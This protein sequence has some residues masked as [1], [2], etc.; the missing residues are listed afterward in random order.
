MQVAGEVYGG[1]AASA[2]AQQHGEQFAV[3][4]PAGAVGDAVFHGV[5]Q[6]G[7]NRVIFMVQGACGVKL[8]QGC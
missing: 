8:E 4:Q 7:A 6:R 3:G 1:Q 5:V 2:G